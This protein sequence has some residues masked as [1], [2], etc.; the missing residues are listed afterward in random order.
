MEMFD[1]IR[2][3]EAFRLVFEKP[4]IIG[5]IEAKELIGLVSF[6]TP[7]AGKSEMPLPQ[8]SEGGV[9]SICNAV[10]SPDFDMLSEESYG[11]AW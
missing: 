1:R 9:A 3:Q 5:E 6:G 4:Q 11:G 7:G 2:A 10:E 8:S